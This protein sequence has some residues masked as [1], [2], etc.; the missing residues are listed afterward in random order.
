MKI[1]HIL[2]LTVLVIT[3][4]N[5]ATTGSIP[6]ASADPDAED[7]RGVVERLREQWGYE[8]VGMRPDGYF[9]ACSVDS[10]FNQE[11]QDQLDAR[12]MDG[13]IQKKCPSGQ[14]LVS[15]FVPEYLIDS[16]ARPICGRVKVAEVVV[17]CQGEGKGALFSSSPA[18]AGME[19]ED[20]QCA[21]GTKWDII[22]RQCISICQ[23][24]EWDALHARCKCSSGLKWYPIFGECRL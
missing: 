22:T 12:L 16:R 2:L 5:C 14:A 9:V 20:H 24:G 3:C 18:R 19:E 21:A 11:S 7:L 6:T 10:F 1:S 23:N 8:T 15:G 13:L 4:T 17:T